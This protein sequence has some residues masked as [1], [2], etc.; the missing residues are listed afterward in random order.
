[1]NT[2]QLVTKARL[3]GVYGVLR[4]LQANHDEFETRCIGTGNCCKV[5]LFISLA[6]CWNIAT[7]LKRRRWLIAEDKGQ[8]AANAWWDKQIE[9]LVEALTV[10]EWDYDHQET[11]TYC[12]F[13]DAE[14]GCTIYE[15][16]PMVCRAYGVIA[17]AETRCGRARL[18]DEGDHEL[19][20]WDMAENVIQEF[21]AIIQAWGG[22]FPGLDY[23]MYMPAGVL[24]FLLTDSDLSAVIEST[25]EKFWQGAQGY[26]HQIN[27]GNWT[28]VE[29]RSK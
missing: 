28:P 14:V 8:S 2:A 10:E 12:N 19:L 17:P 13:S 22:S 27:P 1:M 11:E 25:D 26:T 4:K 16:R 21:D 9:G 7:E 24:R 18:N 20:P 29:I 6:E 15:F 3:E 5:G 23:S